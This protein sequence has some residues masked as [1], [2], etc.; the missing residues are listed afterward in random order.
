MRGARTRGAACG[1]AQFAAAHAEGDTRAFL[2]EAALLTDVDRL[3]E[4]AD[5][6]LLLTA[7]NAKGLEFEAVAIAGLEE[8][9]FPHGSSLDDPTELEEERRLFYV[10]L[11]RA[12]DEVLL[13]AAAIAD[14][15]GS[16][17]SGV[18][19]F[20]DEIRRSCSTS[21]VPPQ[22]PAW[23]R[24]AR[25]RWWRPRSRPRSARAERWHAWSAA[26]CITRASG[27]AWW[28]RP[29]KKV[30]SESSRCASAR[31]S[32][33]C[34][35]AFS[36]G[37]RMAIDRAEVRRI[38]ELARLEIP[39]GDEERMAVEL[40]SVLE[41]VACSDAWISPDA[42]RPRSLPPRPRCVRTRR[43]APPDAEQ[44]LEALGERRQLLPRAAIVENVIHDALRRVIHDE[45]RR[46]IRDELRRV[47]S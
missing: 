18:S 47:I 22:R 24:R 40:S 15:D 25:P 26:R 9:L 42:S 17:G 31:R 16:G 11:T 35:G 5:R 3:A 20:V 19:R 8:G 6:V 2:A 36:R 21:E 4:G 12:K 32:R 41:L 44:A 33:R 37:A 14:V 10:A 29:R 38:A 7:H 39:A 43:W 30:A 46:V 45:L 27:A 34:S 23:N 13:T 1:A 28:W